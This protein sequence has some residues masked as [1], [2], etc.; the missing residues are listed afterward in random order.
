[1]DNYSTEENN[2]VIHIQSASDFV[3][4]PTSVAA[5]L[6]TEKTQISSIVHV[7]TPLS[8][9]ETQNANRCLAIVDIVQ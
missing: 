6:I 5:S 2:K 3:D 7:E 1:M 9:S 8:V 4:P